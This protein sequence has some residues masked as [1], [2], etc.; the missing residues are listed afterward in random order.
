MLE[1]I[2]SKKAFEQRYDQAVELVN[3]QVERYLLQDQK[4]PQVLRQAMLYSLKAGGKRLR[5]VMAILTC[6]AFGGSQEDAL[7]AAVALEMVH[8]YSLIHDDLPAMDDDDYR[9]GQLTNHK[10]FGEGI[11]ILAGDGLLTYAFDILARQQTN[12][13]ITRQLI[14]EL[15]H[16]AGPAGM[17][18]GQVA[19]LTG[20]NSTGDLETVD[21]IHTHKTAMMFRGTCRMGALCGGADKPHIDMAGQFGLKLGLAF[22]IIDDLLDVTATTEQLGK[23]AGKDNLAGKLTYPAILGLEESRRHGQKLKAQALAIIEPLKEKAQPL[24]YLAEMLV[25]RNK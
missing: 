10:V 19:D 18:A 20:Q 17:I 13:S 16:A 6:E 24:R 7:P 4:I 5:P 14:M 25:N 2:T 8:T 11:A 1:T 12:D 21:Y 22:Q 23:Q 9:R 15:A 3:R